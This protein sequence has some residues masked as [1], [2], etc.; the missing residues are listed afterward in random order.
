MSTASLWHEQ[1][2]TNLEMELFYSLT[3]VLEMSSIHPLASGESLDIILLYSHMGSLWHYH[4]L[5]LRDWREKLSRPQ[6]LTRTFT[7][8]HTA[9]ADNFSRLSRVQCM[10]ESSYTGNYTNRNDWEWNCGY[11]KPNLSFLKFCNVSVITAASSHRE[12]LVKVALR[13]W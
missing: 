4:D 7:F 12:G 1:L 10:S 13:P 11:N 9:A 5:L 8:S 3:I 2:Q 6:Q